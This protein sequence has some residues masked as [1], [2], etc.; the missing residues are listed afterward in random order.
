VYIK[1]VKIVEQKQAGNDQRPSGTE[2]DF[3]GRQV[4]QWVRMRRR[5]CRRS[6]RRRRRVHEEQLHLIMQFWVF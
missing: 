4:P 6:R 2:E 5:R 3:I 1:T